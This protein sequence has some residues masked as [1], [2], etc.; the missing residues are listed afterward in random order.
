MYKSKI[1]PNFQTYRKLSLLIGQQLIVFLWVSFSV[2]LKG[3]YN[4]GIKSHKQGNTAIMS[5]VA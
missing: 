3:K 4:A 5:N 2:F 1:L